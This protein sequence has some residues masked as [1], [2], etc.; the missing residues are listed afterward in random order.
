MSK[1]IS[2]LVVDSVQMLITAYIGL[3]AYWDGEEYGW[4]RMP[5]LDGGSVEP[6]STTEFGFI[7]FHS[8]MVCGIDGNGFSPYVPTHKVLEFIQSWLEQSDDYY[9]QAVDRFDQ[10]GLYEESEAY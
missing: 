4:Y 8:K 10:Y 3:M 6:F 2:T 7:A 1:N 5:A 9:F